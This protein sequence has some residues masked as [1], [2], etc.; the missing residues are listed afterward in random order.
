MAER[1]AALRA[2]IKAKEAV[3][4]QEDEAKINAVR[5]EW[6]EQEARE[7]QE[8]KVAREAL[9]KRKQEL[10]AAEAK[11]PRT[12]ERSIPEKC[13]C[14]EILAQ[15]T[16]LKEGPNHGKAFFC[17]SKGKK[18]FGGCGFFEWA[19]KEES[20]AAASV[21]DSSQAA[22]VPSGEAPKCNCGEASVARSVEK[23]CPHFGRAFFH[24]SKG[25]KE[26]GGCGYFMWAQLVASKAL[27]AETMS[28]TNSDSTAVTETATSSAEVLCRCG[29]ATEVRTVAK[30]GPNF[31]RPYRTCPKGKREFGGCGFFDWADSSSSSS[32]SQ[33]A[34]PAT[35]TATAAAQPAAVGEASAAD[36][37]DGRVCRCNVALVSKTVSKD[38]PNFG[39]SFLACAKGKKEFGGCNFFE[40]VQIP[41]AAKAGA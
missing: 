7:L 18:E 25:K 8:K 4:K 36:T 16:V 39:R 15:R 11:K 19:P 17:C 27:A 24:C 41:A 1:L 13:S 22:A 37:S 9:L 40:W 20:P 5:K 10:E 38:G 35:A 28:T 23:D 12:E 2:R 30:E 3:K 34:V 33:P 14:G 26:D 31:G 21:E 29:T 6:N 32:S